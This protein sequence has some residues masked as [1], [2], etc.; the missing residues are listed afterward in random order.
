MN[1]AAILCL[2]ST[3]LVHTTDRPADIISLSPPAGSQAERWSFSRGGEF[4][5]AAGS[6]KAGADGSLHMAYDFT[7]G[8]AYV[9]AY[10][11]LDMPDSMHSLSFRLHNPQPHQ[12][13][14]R[15]FD[16]R[17]QV[18]QKSAV[19][20]HGG[21]NAFTCDMNR[22]T[23]HYGGPNDGILRQ[24]IRRIGI[25]IENG[26]LNDAGEMLIADVAYARGGAESSRTAAPVETAYTVT[27]FGD[28]DGFTATA[29]QLVAGR[30]RIDF[31]KASNVRLGH[32]I[33]LLGSPKSLALTLD[34]PGKGHVLRMRL[35]SHFQNFERTVGTLAGGRQTFI[36]P[37]PPD[38]WT[39]YGGQNDGKV[40]PPL[41][42]S[43]V[44]LERGDGPTEAVEIHLLNIKCTTTVDPDDAVHLRAAIK[45]DRVAAGLRYLRIDCRAHNLLP[46]AR[47]GSLKVDLTD[48]RG[49]RIAEFQA[50]FRLPG[51]GASADF[52][53]TIA[54]DAGLNFAQA[55][56]VFESDDGP[57]AEAVAAFTRPLD[58]P[59]DA[60]LKPESPWGMGV[61]L[62][63]YPNNEHGLRR[64]DAAAAMARAAGVKWSRE[65]FNWGRMQPR[66][67]QI[68]FDFYD[69]V[70]DTARRHG[71]SVYGLLAY[72]SGWTKPYTHEGIE[73]FC[74]WARAVVARYKDRV[75]H[76]EIYNEPNIF[77]WSGPRELYPVLMK[78][79]HD[80]IKEVDPEAQV[81]GIST[82]GIDRQFIR[83]CL[84]TKAPFDIL[85]IHPYRGLLS[86][87][88]FMDELAATAALV[89]NRPVW[90]T[91]MGWSTQIGNVSER[92]QAQLL[93]RCYLAA[94]ASGACQNVSWYNFR[95]DGDDP[96]YNE[97][98]FGVLYS[99]LRPKPA[100]RA[101]ATVCRTLSEGKP[102]LRTEF[103][104]NIHAIQMGEA[105][106][107]WTTGPNTEVE[108][109]RTAANVRALNLMGEPLSL[110]KRPGRF[111]ITLQKASPV[112]IIGPVEPTGIVRA[113][114]TG[115][116][117]LIRF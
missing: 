94:A 20:D 40:R 80:A 54:I 53:Q 39:H 35:G 7:G 92:A 44:I 23:G 45:E 29:S 72:W 93:A 36:I 114:E 43:A 91:E 83:M 105:L 57:P 15:V 49:G 76:W 55:N 66:P 32:S 61:Y 52:T 98:N 109:R 101:L 34:S 1:I 42:L 51:Q 12:I 30:W 71:I 89:D 82:A 11:D 77:F 37:M 8:G 108:L 68:D 62:Y 50:A 110:P 69:K 81:L 88:A 24:P 112:F 113:I 116:P 19:P 48:W 26:A 28:E 84:D 17:G 5:G 73:D 6:L 4:P 58:D 96:Y 2:A 25:L 9:A 78:K 31:A 75:K 59:G 21:W 13:T 102:V 115:R 103:G 85:T 67:D 3:A 65:E 56:L 90:I 97:H 16:S 99:D 117:A 60:L 86:E 63:R 87:R 107:L 64:M 46:A 33:S 18:F 41:R 111:T 38:G 104:D 79:C 95:N 27:E 106:A 74:T 22:W 70:V 14:V 10:R 100:Y 47:H